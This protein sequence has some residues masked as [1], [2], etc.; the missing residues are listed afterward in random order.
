MNGY[1]GNCAHVHGHSWVI[2]FTCSG[3]D[4]DKFGMLRDFGSF[5]IIRKWVDDFLDHATIVSKDDESLIRWLHTNNQR[6]YIT[7]ENPTSEF[8]AKL[9]F[10]KCKELGVHDIHSVTVEETC[11]SKAVYVY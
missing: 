5:K 10:E 3:N 11:T 7:Q 8:L 1:P 6:H 4:L 2:K 9:L